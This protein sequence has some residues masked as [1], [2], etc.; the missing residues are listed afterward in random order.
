VDG[1]RPT[2]VV[3]LRLYTY[4]GIIAVLGMVP[5]IAAALPDFEVA[6]IRLDTRAEAER[7]TTVLPGGRLSAVHLD[8]R[9]MI[10]NAF[11]VEDYQISGAPR[12]IDSTSYAIEAKM[13]KGVEITRDDI[14][15]LLL[16]LLEKRFHLR[17]HREVT[18]LKEYFLEVAK[19]GEKLKRHIGD[20]E[21]FSNTNS[22]GGVVTL[23]ARKV[24]M[25]DFA[26]SLRRQL[27]RPVTDKTG[28]T[29][30]FD[31]DLTWSNEEAVDT[32]V[33]S[34]FASL[35]E[36]GLRLVSVKGP[37]ELIVIDGIEK[38]SEN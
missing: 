8:V 33:P 2:F 24:P 22:H 31:F 15:A 1:F 28:L 7:S 17:Y 12:W 34:L 20:G 30:E 25:S 10:R 23:R 14:P 29:G 36:L 5:V 35:Q 11:D 21:T 18:K 37:V 3:R 9:K 19:S 32:T 27:G 13:P 16:S 6:A 38:A 26:Y 4:M